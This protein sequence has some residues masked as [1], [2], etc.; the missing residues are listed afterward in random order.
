MVNRTPKRVAKQAAAPEYNDFFQAME[1]GDSVVKQSE[2]D[3][4]I[5]EQ[6]SA[7]MKRVDDLSSQNELLRSQPP[8]QINAPQAAPVQ[9]QEQEQIPDPV[10]H[11]AEYTQWLLRRA[12]ALAQERIN[13]VVA[14]QQEQ[15]QNSDAYENLWTN[16]L[17]VEGNDVWEDEPEKVEV[18]ARKVSK[19]LQAKGIDVNTYMFQHSDRFFKDITS[20]LEK[21][22]GKPGEA[23]ETDEGDDVDRTGGLMGGQ[24]APINKAKTDNSV[25]PDMLGDLTTIQRKGGWY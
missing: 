11:G 7:L 1:T 16:F 22:F 4:K 8:I 6:L 9:Q 20:T 24:P 2:V 15:A 17:A 19:K 21:D 18:A 12:D 10:L 23:E 25:G 13:A 3:N 5:S 14:A